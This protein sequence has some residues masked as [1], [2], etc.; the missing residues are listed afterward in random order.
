MLKDDKIGVNLL[1][2]HLVL[3]LYQCMKVNGKYFM[4]SSHRSVVYSTHTI[5]LVGRHTED[6]GLNWIATCIL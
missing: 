1:L 6:V 2:T 5:P 3:I 4:S